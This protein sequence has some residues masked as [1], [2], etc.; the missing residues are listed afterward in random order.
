MKFLLWALF[1]SFSIQAK[2]DLKKHPIYAQIIKNSPK[3]NK[4]YAMRLSNIIHQMHKK[5][6][7]PS[8]VFTAILKQE[9]NYS[10]KAKGCH[11]GIQQPSKKYIETAN[12][13]CQVGDSN[14]PESNIKGCLKSFPQMNSIEV[15]VCTDFGISQIYFKTAKRFGFDLNLLTTD[16]GY[17]VEAGAKVLHDFMERYEAK[18]NDWWVRYNCGSRGTTKRD[19]CQI[20]KKLVERYM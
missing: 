2:V 1:I 17:S 19:T 13:V 11:K 9:S 15:K 7:I 3:I 6:H 14:V 8:R 18:D 12:D 4:R 16:L 5:Y 10:L 20:Y